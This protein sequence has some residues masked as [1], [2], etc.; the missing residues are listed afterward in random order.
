MVHCATT[1]PITGPLL[2]KNSKNILSADSVV[3]SI[4]IGVSL[5]NAYDDDDTVDARLHDAARNTLYYQI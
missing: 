2:Y 5:F 4:H 1:G 3:M